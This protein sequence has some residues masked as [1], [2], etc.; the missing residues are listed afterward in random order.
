MN[1]GEVVELSLLPDTSNG[2]FPEPPASGPIRVVEARH[3]ACGEATRVRLPL[4]VPALAVRHLHCARCGQ[5][6]ETSLIHELGIQEEGAEAIV[7]RAQNDLEPEAGSD[8]F[9]LPDF[10]LPMFGELELPGAK[11]VE[12]MPVVPEPEPV[13][14]RAEP[15]AVEPEPVFVEPDPVPA[16]P[17]PVVVQPAPAPQPVAPVAEEPEPFAPGPKFASKTADEDPFKSLR[18]A[19]AVELMQIAEEPNV[20]DAQ[21]VVDKPVAP[22]EVVAAPAPAHPPAPQPAKKRAEVKLPEVRLPAV[23]LPEIKLPQVKLPNLSAVKLPQLSAIKLP[24][25]PELK[26]PALASSTVTLPKLPQLS[27]I[28]P[29]SPDFRFASAAA[30]VVAVIMLLGAVQGDDKPI[31]PQLAAATEQPKSSS[32]LPSADELRAANADSDKVIGDSRIPAD[33]ETAGKGS[34]ETE[35]VRG[36]TYSLAL[37]A[38][39]EQT[40]TTQGTAAFAAQS[41]D[42]GADAQLWISED[43]KLDFPAFINLS[44]QQL[45]SLAGSAEVV[46]RIPGP[47]PETTI[48]RLAADAPEGQPS[49]EVTL[50]AAGPYRY[51]LATSVQP[52]ASPEAVEGVELIVGSFTPEGSK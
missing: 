45:E 39:W 27:K 51:Y 25:L 47:T 21:T 16:Q 24:K 10:N 7:L 36:S 44:L 6:F 34:E 13:I 42:G 33:D 23:K 32:D 37:T 40:D 26:R 2:G 1:D 41:A 38:G 3:A 50:R 31:A 29:S 15:V 19:I 8:R 46:E 52:D 28:D 22:Q 20:A 9:A 48:V 11:P 4:A 12:P 35:L 18:D 5:D 43:P 30:A 17:D 49:Y 14:F